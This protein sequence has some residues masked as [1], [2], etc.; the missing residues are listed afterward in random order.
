M[1]SA[2]SRIAGH[3]PVPHIITELPGPKARA[4]VAFDEAWTSASLPRAYPIVPVR[5]EGLTVEDIDG[6]LFLDFAAGIAVNSTGHA[7]PQV[8]AAI[9]E[10]AA[11]LIHFSAS[12][13][14]LPIYAQVCRELARIAPISGR[15]RAYLGN[16]GTEVVE[17]AMK[18]AR[19]ATKRPYLVAFLGAFHGRTYGS[20]SL[21]AS[22]AKYHAG[23]GPL[24]PGIF[25]APYG[26]VEDLRWFDEVLFDKL[27]PA[28]EV[29]AIIVEPIQ[30][31]G[32]YIV[33]EDGFLAGLR[34]ICDAHGILLIAD[35]I[36]S[37]AGRTG[38]MWA[39]EHWGV[40]PDILLTAKG[41]ASGMTLGALIARAELL[42][43][44]GPG[45][46]GSTFGGNPVAC[47]AA[48]A[49][50]DLLEGGLIE[51]AAA[52]GAQA[53][54]GLAALRAR[55]PALISDVRGRGLMLGVE[56]D[57][58]EHA[59]AVQWAAFQKGL[60]VLECGRSSIR[61]SPAL[62]VSEAEMA[63][64]L[65]IL[66]ESVATVAGKPAA[67]EAGQPGEPGETLA[68]R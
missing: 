38:R 28:A 21:T 36:Q 2:A 7:H 64:A 53:M 46:H 67:P 14:Y 61:L 5:G 29:A 32:G 30:G 19:F 39:V 42:E 15:V 24:L 4:H 33:P 43:A 50:I 9:K 52:R 11:E 22:K 20:V 56:F 17:A 35:E 57:T 51:N 63:T 60:L 3:R 23:F 68:A 13:F 6:N 45:A 37:G 16:S 12:D 49:T 65:R 40:E 44:W 27:A 41:I 1:S 54:I 66:A 55:H 62:T 48:L 25:H 10:Q 18:L 8:V 34:R 59:E 31:E 26:R 47:A 58:I